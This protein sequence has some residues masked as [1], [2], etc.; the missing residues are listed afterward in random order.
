MA[1]QTYDRTIF[2]VCYSV[3]KERSKFTVVYVEVTGLNKTLFVFVS[4]G[5]VEPRQSIFQP[6]HLAEI[7]SA[8]LPEPFAFPLSARCICREVPADCSEHLYLV[9]S[10]LIRHALIRSGGRKQAQALRLRNLCPPF[11]SKVIIPSYSKMALGATRKFHERMPQN[12]NNPPD[13]RPEDY[14]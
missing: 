6:S 2:F 11:H 8:R 10:L 9:R 3:F 4:K 5:N 7:L 1:K 13:A 14:F 12:G